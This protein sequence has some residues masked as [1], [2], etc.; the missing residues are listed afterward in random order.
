[1]RRVIGMAVLG[2]VLC[3]TALA[4]DPL[5]HPKRVA[6]V[7]GN[8]AYRKDNVAPDQGATALVAAVNDANDI[9]AEL[10]NLGFEVI[11]KPDCTIKEMRT[12]IDE[13][14][15]RL[16]RAD[17]ALFY[18][19]GHGAQ[20]KD[21][22]YMLPIGAGDLDYQEFAQ[23]TVDVEDVYA[24]LRRGH[25]TFNLVILDACRTNP[26]LAV[27]GGDLSLGAWSSGL[28]EPKNVPAGT[29]VAFA[30][31]PGHIADD[32]G[33]NP[34]HSHYS[35]ALL[36]YMGEP[37]LAVQDFFVR[38]N[39]EFDPHQTPWENTSQKTPFMF[40]DPAYVEV[41]IDG[42]DDEASI[43]MN[44]QS[45]TSSMD[46]GRVRLLRLAPGDN[47]LTVRLYNQKT[48]RGAVGPREG[49]WYDAH[50]K[51]HDDAS[52][53]VPLH[54][55]EPGLTDAEFQAAAFEALSHGS[56]KLGQPFNPPGQI[57]DHHWGHSF[58]TAAV[59]IHVSRE[60]V[61]TFDEVDDQVSKDEFAVADNSRDILDLAI[62]WAVAHQGVRLYDQ[63]I[64][65]ALRPMADLRVAFLAAH[66]ESRD[67][68][69]RV[70]RSAAHDLAIDALKQASD[71][72][73]Q[74]AITIA[75]AIEM[76]ARGQLLSDL[77]WSVSARPEIRSR[78]T[79]GN[80]E[81]ARTVFYELQ[82][83]NPDVRN[84]LAL[85]SNGDLQRLV[86]SMR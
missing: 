7:I 46:Q 74:G 81:Q 80:P 25:S 9:A 50:L 13:F 75:R 44:G 17:Q 24:A 78:A 15:A 62:S 53:S 22:N 45:I 2:V 23:K 36:H 35:S 71:S 38:V 39:R 57:L 21:H 6:L 66:A 43:L 48:T 55:G 31:A 51:I 63:A 4:Q 12:F 59:R 69:G 11:G 19:S 29:I 40:R 1:M 77:G 65:G 18:Y 73:L 76:D 86:S 3:G 37:G 56:L 83:N 79:G 85:V 16:E 33:V 60:G 84:E 58:I 52:H 5:I 26:F 54:A 47:L 32:T 8:G 41:T 27:G 42:A 10:R 68:L 30:T 64:P 34:K 20:V 49:W 61:A 70:I 14:A 72:A 82:Q 67:Y 28:A